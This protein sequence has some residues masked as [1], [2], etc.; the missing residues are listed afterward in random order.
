M[1]PEFL[2]WL[3]KEG[4]V[5]SM[6]ESKSVSAVGKSSSKSS[7]T[8]YSRDRPA[9]RGSCYS[10]NEEGH[11]SMDCPNSEPAD[12]GYRQ[13]GGGDRKGR[14][15]RHR[16]FNCAYCKNDNTFCQTWKCM[17]FETVRLQYSQANSGREWRLPSLRW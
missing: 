1:F 2:N 16:K 7:T 4:N 3:E 14:P 17:R 15:N 13:K 11:R 5:W 9:F 8:L 6:M 12:S 10:C